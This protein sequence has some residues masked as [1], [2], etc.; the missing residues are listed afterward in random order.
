MKAFTLEH[1]RAREIPSAGEA[2]ATLHSALPKPSDA[3][4]EIAQLSSESLKL[5]EYSCLY[6]ATQFQFGADSFH[7]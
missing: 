3:E 4:S 2:E 6:N 5:W 7:V 1:H